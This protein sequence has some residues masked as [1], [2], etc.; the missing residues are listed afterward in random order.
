MQSKN[1]PMDAFPDKTSDDTNNAIPTGHIDIAAL[2]SDSL[3]QQ[4]AQFETIANRLQAQIQSMNVNATA[5]YTSQ[6]TQEKSTSSVCQ[7]SLLTP[8]GCKGPQGFNTISTPSSAKSSKT[9][10]SL[11][12]KTAKVPT[13]PCKLQQLQIAS[14]T[15]PRAFKSFMDVLYVHIK[16]M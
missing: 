16:M 5:S 9:P 3:K 8:L 4:A 11:I 1:T 14:D 15:T 7:P 6:W 2:I 10:K 12:K 13:P